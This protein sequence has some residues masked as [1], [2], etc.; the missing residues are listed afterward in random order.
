MQRIYA[1]YHTH[2]RHSHGQGT[3][4]DNVRAAID[5]G[6]HTVA[7]SDHGP[8][9]LF[10]VGVRNLGVFQAIRQEIESCQS[11]FPQ[12]KLLLGVK[13]NII[14]IDGTL[15]IPPEA[16]GQFDLILA[17]LHPLVY[18]AD[19]ISGLA[20]VGNLMGRHW[21]YLSNRLR[22]WNTKAVISALT[23]YPIDILTHPGLHMNIDTEKVASVCAQVGTYMEI[24]TGHD[25]ISADYLQIA[26]RAGT[27]FV[28]S[29]DAHTPSRVGDAAK[30]L[31]LARL[32]KI[33]CFAIRN[34]ASRQE[35]WPRMEKRYEND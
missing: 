15:D 2:T 9:N 22:P 17:G 32:A 23:R 5:A 35:T 27:R 14:G 24:N 7:I 28:I 10:G 19:L 30:G 6:L 1:D 29:S 12:I 26:F 31:K 25:H 20:M 33:P 8:A 16:L 11:K 21:Q 18:P 34:T 3:V 13:A 4:E